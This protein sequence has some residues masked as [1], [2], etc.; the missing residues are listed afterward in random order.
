MSN[1]EWASRFYTQ[2]PEAKKKYTKRS[3]TQRLQEI[4]KE[5]DFD[6]ITEEEVKRARGNSE[7]YKDKTDA[8]IAKIPGVEKNID[9]RYM[10]QLKEEEALTYDLWKLEPTAENYAKYSTALDNRTIQE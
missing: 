7:F 9:T 10:R 8:E 3:I 1:L 4:D 5:P 6:K 2:S